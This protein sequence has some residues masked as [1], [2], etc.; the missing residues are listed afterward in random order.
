MNKPEFYSKAES[1]L[2]HLF[3]QIQ[4]HHV[5]LR[6]HWSIDHLCFRVQSLESYEQQKVAFASFGQLLI[7]SE[8]KGRM[9][10]TFKLPEAVKFRGYHIDLVELPAPKQGKV[11]IEGFEHVEVVT[12]L[13]FESLRQKYAGLRLDEGG[14]QKPF[15]QELEIEMQDC[16]LK[17]HPLSLESVITLEKNQKVYGALKKSLVLEIFKA[18]QPMVAGSFP[19]GLEVSGSDLDILL[20]SSDLKALHKLAE[21][22]FGPF[23]KYEA[24][25]TEVAGLESLV[26]RF[27]F[28]GVS[29]ELFAQAT[30]SLQQVAYRHFQIEERLVRFVPNTNRKR[31]HNQLRRRDEGGCRPLVFFR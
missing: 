12:D 20:T 23:Q 6:S 30:E 24:Q 28:E 26:I 13:P 1:F 9:I 16:A 5:E 17:F 21:T 4:T 7:E 2:N 31:P 14:L 22:S 29:F 10:A 15:N 3:A 25:F 8:V 27:D 18:C 19:L 11:T